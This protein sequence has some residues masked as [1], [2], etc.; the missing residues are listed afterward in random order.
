MGIYSIFFHS[1]AQ[2]QEIF[3]IILVVLGIECK[4]GTPYAH[5]LEILWAVD[6]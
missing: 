4:K 3:A 5:I 2:T 1:N 6:E